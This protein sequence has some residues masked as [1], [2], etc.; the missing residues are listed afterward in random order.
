MKLPANVADSD[1]VAWANET[2]IRYTDEFR[3]EFLRRY[4][5]GESPAR[6][7]RDHG[8]GPELIG[9]K[10]IE[11]A[12]RRWCDR[13]GQPLNPSRETILKH[14]PD[15]PTAPDPLEDWRT[16]PVIAAWPVGPH[17]YQYGIPTDPV[18]ACVVVAPTRREILLGRADQTRDDT[19]MHVHVMT[20]LAFLRLA[21]KGA[22]DM[23][24]PQYLQQLAL[25]TDPGFDELLLETM[26]MTTMSTLRTGLTRGRAY[27]NDAKQVT[28]PM[29]RRLQTAHALRCLTCARNACT[30]RRWT[31]VS[32]AL[33]DGYLREVRDGRSAPDLDTVLRM[34]EERIDEASLPEETDR[35]TRERAERIAERLHADIVDHAAPSYA[36]FA[37]FDHAFT[38]YKEERHAV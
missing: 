22:P 30:T 31:P 9:Y 37:E 18:E 4:G 8:L 32:P 19:D 11:R 20:P 13:A 29:L 21:L 14:E 16:R 26:G 2:A 23:I 28:D 36:T 17:A 34:T 10:R 25:V 27:A 7:F 24:E 1:A 6:I 33:P 5:N 38:R 15:R 3:R 35:E 12:T